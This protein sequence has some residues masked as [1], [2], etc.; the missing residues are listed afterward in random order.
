MLGGAVQPH[1]QNLYKKRM[2][3]FTQAIFS[4]SCARSYRHFLFSTFP[5]CMPDFHIMSSSSPKF[6]LK[7]MHMHTFV[8]LNQSGLFCL[9]PAIHVVVSEIKKVKMGQEV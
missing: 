8:S 3:L 2:H 6:P 5:P 4:L 1:I 9:Q 7:V